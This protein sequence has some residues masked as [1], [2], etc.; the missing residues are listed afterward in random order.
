MEHLDDALVGHEVEEGLQVDAG[1]ERID[2]QALVRRRHLDEAE[3]RVIGRL[4]HELRVDGDERVLGETRTG[5]CKVR[6]R[7]DEIHRPAI[8]EAARRFKP[9][10]ATRI[11]ESEFGLGSART[12]PYQESVIV[13]CRSL[14][15]NS[16]PER[17]T[18]GS[19]LKPSRAKMP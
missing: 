12:G 15:L 11:R 9:V 13:N 1:R 17:A 3:L 8:A 10:A 4:A 7:G 6:G 5:R 18:E 2:E 16:S 14:K 19:R